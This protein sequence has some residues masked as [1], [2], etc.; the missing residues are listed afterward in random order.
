[1]A[2]AQL[3]LRGGE[4]FVFKNENNGASCKTM[5]DLILSVRHI[6]SKVNEK[7]TEIVND[8]KERTIKDLKDEGLWIESVRYLYL[9]CLIY[10]CIYHR[11]FAA[12]TSGYHSP[13]RMS[14]QSS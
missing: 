13:L 12:T 8:Q 5:K 3:I 7:L 11:F 6:Q 9:K 2:E 14:L 10:S 1:M 4:T